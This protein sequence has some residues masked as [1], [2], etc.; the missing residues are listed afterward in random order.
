MALI[1]ISDFNQP[2][3]ECDGNSFEVKS[4]SKK[5]ADFSPMILTKSETDVTRTIFTPKMVDNSKSPNMCI[6]GKITYEKRQKNEEYPSEKLSPHNIRVGELMEISLNTEAIYN[7]FSYLSNLY[8]FHES[9]GIPQGRRTFSQVD[10]RLC[11]LL[12]FLQ[13]D[14]EVNDF[15]TNPQ[16]LDLTKLLFQ[17]ITQI[18]SAGALLDVLNDLN[19]DNISTLNNSISLERL[20]RAISLIE[21][22]LDNNSEEFW[23]AKVFKDNQWILSQLFATPCTIL[24]DKAY[25]GGKGIDNQRGN[26]VDF[27]YLNKLS[28]NVALIEIKTPKTKIIQNK[29]RQSYSFTEEMSGSINQVINYRNSLIKNYNSIH[30][31]SSEEFK[32]FSPKCIVIIGKIK[33]MNKNE[34]GAFEN[35]RHS[36]NNIEIITFDEILQKIK[37]LRALFV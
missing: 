36:L 20:N 5:T 7:L 13:N 8:G 16:S 35:Y 29:Y 28:E 24:D 15:L 19:D 18:H 37:D 6:S 22:N 25:V 4:S 27:I 23:Q 30:D 1:P 34:I 33:D 2:L 26:I 32:V 17:R 31:N 12:D 21:D 3:K 10:S 14:S 11:D 9:N